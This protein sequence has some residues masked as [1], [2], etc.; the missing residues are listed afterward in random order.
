MAKFFWHNLKVKEIEKTLRT[1]INKGLDRKEVGLR[2]LEF[3]KNELPEE[4]PLSRLKIFLEQFKSPLTYILVI[5]GFVVLI[6]GEFTDAIVI[7]G[8]VF[9]NTTIGYFQENKA[10]QALVKLKKIVKHHAEVLRESN[11]KVVSL[12]ELVS[13]DIVILNPGDIV[14]ADGRIITCND[15]KVNEMALTG[16]WISAEKKTRSNIKRNSVS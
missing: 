10:S 16:E 11:F 14:P 9:L 5:A 1:N 3:G 4:K 7:F 2:Q 13:G 12:E 15:L 6:L 8:A